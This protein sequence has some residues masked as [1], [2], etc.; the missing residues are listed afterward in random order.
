M[1]TPAA[2]PKIPGMTF[3][4]HLG[5]GGF[6]DV[7]RY[8][9]EVPRRMVAVKVWRGQG[10]PE[11]KRA[12]EVETN[13]MAQIAAHPAVVSVFAAGKTK[14]DRPYLVMEYCPPPDLGARCKKQPMSVA[15]ALEVGILLAGAVQTMHQAG[16][17]HRDI[18]PANVLLTRYEKP[19]LTDFGIASSAVAS[20][21]AAGGFS[22][23]WAPPE[24]QSEWGVVGPWTDI[25]SL[26]AT[27]YTFLTGHPPF[28][29]PG[30]DNTEFALMDRSARSEVTP[31]ARDDVPPELFRILLAALSPRPDQRYNSALEF[32]YAL[33]QV[34]EH[35]EQPVTTMEVLG[36]SSYEE[37]STQ[38]PI[39]DVRANENELKPEVGRQAL[40]NLEHTI[41]ASDETRMSLR[42]LA[43]GMQSQLP[44]YWQVDPRSSTLET[45]QLKKASLARRIVPWAA[46]VALLGG[47]VTAGWYFWPEARSEKETTQSTEDSDQNEE[48]SSPTVDGE[49]KNSGEFTYQ[50]DTFSTEGPSGDGSSSLD[51]PPTSPQTNPVHASI[52]DFKGEK[53]GS[54][55]SL[56]WDIS[57]VEDSSITPSY[58]VIHKVDGVEQG[59]AKEIW[60]RSAIFDLVKGENCFVMAGFLNGVQVTYTRTACVYYK[61]DTQ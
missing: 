17:I 26:A 2:P 7:F 14:D 48:A 50:G 39:P 27:I 52:T 21:S 18:K 12:F 22:L 5:S 43:P 41:Q 55:Y 4:E 30:G 6:A 32:A 35:L 60:A 51:N 38:G 8:E 23:P 15:R 10:G 42:V 3:R 40:E 54:I 47:F 34:Q 57:G 9:Q 28:V 11:A 13:L 46:A 1:P 20:N 56:T 58:R 19:V 29:I 49:E 25:Y 36:A 37:V 45:P 53:V 24:Q 61:G 16:I 44:P 31:L 33:Q 59:P